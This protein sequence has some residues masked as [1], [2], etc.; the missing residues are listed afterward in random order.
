LMKF[1]NLNYIFLGD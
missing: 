1:Q